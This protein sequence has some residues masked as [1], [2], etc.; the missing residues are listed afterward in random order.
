MGSKIK[1]RR[2]SILLHAV[3]FF[4]S[5][6]YDLPL[7]DRDLHRPQGARRIRPE[8]RSDP[9]GNHSQ[10]FSGRLADCQCALVGLQQL[11][12]YGGVGGV[13]PHFWPR[14][15]LMVSPGSIS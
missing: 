9:L 10:Q 1:F 3:L 11:H 12:R 8:Q 6:I 5:F 13:D 15:R 14:W 4:V 2:K 7:A